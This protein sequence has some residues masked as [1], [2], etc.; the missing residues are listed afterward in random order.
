MQTEVTARLRELHTTLEASG[1]HR[2][3]LLQELAKNL[4]YWTTVVRREKAVYHTLNKMSVDV[5]SKVLIAEAWVPSVAKAEVQAALRESAANSS[6]QVGYGDR[7]GGWNT[8]YR[9][10][11]GQLVGAADLPGFCG[12]A[13][14]V[15]RTV[16]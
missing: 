12:Y 1:R 8:A 7:G 3:A 2:D 4:D 11:A 15:W 10:P 16:G 9:V 5:T 13:R 14:R 6:T